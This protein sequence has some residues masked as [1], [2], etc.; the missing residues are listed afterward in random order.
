MSRDITKCCPAEEKLRTQTKL[1]EDNIFDKV[2]EVDLKKTMEK[3]YIELLA[4][5]FHYLFQ[6]Y[7]IKIL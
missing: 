1:M 5:Y 2:Q 6:D 4:L 7:L 3:S